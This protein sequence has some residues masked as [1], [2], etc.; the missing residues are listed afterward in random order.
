MIKNII[1]CMILFIVCMILGYS[2]AQIESL[3]VILLLDIL[4]IIP[5]TIIIWAGVYK[6]K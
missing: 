1:N 4:L 5:V 2:L 6:K 3:L